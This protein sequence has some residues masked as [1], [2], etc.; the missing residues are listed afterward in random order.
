ML[1]RDAAIWA[2]RMFLGRE[3][4]SEDEIEVHRVHLHVESLRYAFADSP[5]FQT[6]LRSTARGGAYRAPLFLLEPP[7]GRDFPTRFELPTLARPTSQLCTHGQFQEPEYA[8]W[9]DALHTPA[10]EHRKYWE[11]AYILQVMRSAGVMRPG[12]RALG[13]G[14]GTEPLPAFLASRGVEVVATDAPIE[15]ITGVGWDTT[16]QHAA[17]LAQLF[18]PELVEK[19][20]FDSLVS[21]RPVDMNAIDPDLRGFDVCW[22]ACCFEHLGSIKHGLDFFVASMDTL[23]PGG[24]AVHTTEFNLSSNTETLETG[25]ISIFRKRDIEALVSRLVAAGHEVWPLN[26]HPGA[27]G[28]DERVDVPPFGLPHIKLELAG[29]ACTS[30]GIIARK[31][32]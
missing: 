18:M 29:Y 19:A 25:S 26:L 15:A 17:T 8:E 23:K 1:D 20:I 24:I 28:A 22:S 21:F 12:C 9:C 7:P 10:V 16:G 32:G 30:V 6:F 4:Q 11:F 13:F 5:E 27:S 14:V 3:P 31:R 2:I